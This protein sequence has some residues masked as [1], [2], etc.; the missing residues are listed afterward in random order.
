MHAENGNMQGDDPLFG[1]GK[2]FPQR[3]AQGAGA[4][5]SPLSLSS[6]LLSPSNRGVPPAAQKRARSAQRPRKQQARPPPP[7]VS[8][9]PSS[10]LLASLRACGISSPAAAGAA[11]HPPCSPSLPAR[12]VRAAG[13]EGG[14]SGNSSWFVSI[15]RGDGKVIILYNFRNK[16]VENEW[17][18]II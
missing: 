6:P 18:D 15:V 7:W 3:K 9:L 17:V 14:P 2:H 13:R 8:S 1:W 11:S 5:N 16:Q 12:G 10:L 4:L